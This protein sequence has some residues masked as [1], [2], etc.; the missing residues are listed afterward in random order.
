MISTAHLQRLRARLAELEAN[1]AE[2]SLA[3]DMDR[4]RKLMAEH[5]RLKKTREAADL[6]EK[7]CREVAGHEALVAAPETE[8]ELAALAREELE[9]LRPARA[10]AER[11]LEIALLPP[12]PEDQRNVIV[13]IRAGTGGDEAALFAADLYRMYTRHAEQARSWKTSVID[14]NPSSIGGYKEIIFMVEG[15]DVYRHLRYESGVHRVQRIPATEAND[16]IHT[17]TATVAILPE[18]D[19]IDEIEIR[20]EDLRIDV[21]RASGAGGQHVNKTDSAV[22]MTHL[23]SG[24]VVQSQEERSQ[25]RNREKAMRALRARLLDQKLSAATALQD[26]TRRSQVGSGERNE[27]IRTYNFPQNRL[28]DHRINLT[29]YKLDRIIEGDLD[30]LI[31]ALADDDSA[32]R[33]Q[34]GLDGT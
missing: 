14:A 27:R 32:R 15:Q 1:L 12:R 5:T 3:A 21:Y 10:S 2:P 23:P 20:T 17:S 11:R 13:E 16:R 29:L 6:Y 22:R 19:E 31:Q 18:A 9:Q 30:E 34:A 4:Y 25:H 26:A 7:L 33:L 24:I 28:T 8:P